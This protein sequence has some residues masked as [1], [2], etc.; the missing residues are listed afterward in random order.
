M[1]QLP[2][3]GDL[4]V[5][6]TRDEHGKIVPRP[7]NFKIGPMPQA[8]ATMTPDQAAMLMAQIEQKAQQK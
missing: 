1:I 3:S 5:A 7:D 2:L 4:W 6:P 8:R